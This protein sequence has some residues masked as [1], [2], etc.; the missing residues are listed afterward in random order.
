VPAG[1][2]RRVAILAGLALV[3]SLGVRPLLAQGSLNPCTLLTA[4]E[5]SGV[6]G[7]KSL[8]GRPWLGTSKASCFFSADTSYDLGARTVTVMVLTTAAFDFGKQMSSDG[9]LAGRS[10]GVGDD[11]Y[12]VSVG[13]YAKLGVRRGDHAFS[14]T[15]T[16]GPGKETPD[17]V[18]DLEK[19]LAKDAAG[20][21]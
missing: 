16:P 11:S 1:R 14:I 20:R 6:L 13:H 17:Q 4:V 3:G 9:P 10:A 19:A 5:V 21:L 15:V 7:I 18:A 8:P 2:L 12:Y